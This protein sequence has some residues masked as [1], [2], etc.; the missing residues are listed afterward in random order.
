MRL[1]SQLKYP[2][3]FPDFQVRYIR[4]LAANVLRSLSYLKEKCKAALR[5]QDV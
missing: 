4:R 1:V 3:F 5:Q 2:W